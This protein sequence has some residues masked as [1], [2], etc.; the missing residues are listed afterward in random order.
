MKS[1][2]DLTQLFAK[3]IAFNK[4]KV[5]RLPQMQSAVTGQNNSVFI[6]CRMD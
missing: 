5:G 4:E 1:V 3:S 2:N 6:S